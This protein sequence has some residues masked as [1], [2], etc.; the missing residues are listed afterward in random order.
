MKAPHISVIVILAI[1][2]I[3]GVFCTNIA[4]AEPYQ[5]K[6]F[7]VG[8]KNLPSE[9]T[10]ILHY[11]SCGGQPFFSSEQLSQFVLDNNPQLN[12]SSIDK[13]KIRDLIVPTVEKKLVVESPEFKSLHGNNDS[14]I[15]DEKHGGVLPAVCFAYGSI[16]TFQ[17][18]S[19]EKYRV[20]VGISPGYDYS[21]TLYPDL[22][23]QSSNA[24]K[25]LD[26]TQVELNSENGTQ[27]VRIYNPN[28]AGIPLDFLH[29]SG[30]NGESKYFDHN[31]TLEPRQDM[32]VQLNRLQPS[33]SNVNNIISI[34]SSYP[35]IYGNNL[36]TNALNDSPTTWTQTPSLTDSYNDSQTWQYDGTQWIF[37]DKQVAVPEFPFAIPILFASMMSILIFYRMKLS[38]R[39]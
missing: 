1:F 30:S 18:D 2:M 23:L 32:V 24:T 34:D 37:T 25:Y 13:S 22:G 12:S 10:D 29:L 6:V 39:I 20:Y 19:D 14:L 16:G 9:I 36:D 3:V 15:F 17:T 8:P 28:L 27:W 7:R 26:I 21:F 11:A 5:S 4:N 38:F 33:W 35:D 31:S